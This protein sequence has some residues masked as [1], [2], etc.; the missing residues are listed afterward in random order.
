[1]ALFTFGFSS[2]FSIPFSGLVDGGLSQSILPASLQDEKGIIRFANKRQREMMNVVTET[3]AQAAR[4]NGV[5]LILQEPIGG[6]SFSGIAMSPAGGRH[7]YG[8][9][10]RV[11]VATERRNLDKFGNVKF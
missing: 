6:K 2:A 3:S 9:T 1:M 8:K 4:V 5:V 11:V 10:S 7:I